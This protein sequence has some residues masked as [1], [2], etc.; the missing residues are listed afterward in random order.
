MKK[1]SDNFLLLFAQL[2][3]KKKVKKKVNLE[4]SSKIFMLKLICFFILHK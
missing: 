3:K 4:F 2:I 1:G